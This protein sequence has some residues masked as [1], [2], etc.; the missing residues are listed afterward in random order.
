MKRITPT[1]K[2]LNK[3]KESGKFKI[4]ASGGGGFTLPRYWIIEV[5]GGE[6][7]IACKT[8]T[9]KEIYEK[10]KGGRSEQ[11]EKKNDL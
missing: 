5:P 7:E 1:Q 11:D 4:I 3:F 2:I 10:Y 8:K 9:L 6:V